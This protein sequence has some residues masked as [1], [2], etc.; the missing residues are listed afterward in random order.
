MQPIAK[1][2]DCMGLARS[3]DTMRLCILDQFKAFRE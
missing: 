2:I 3:F 1:V